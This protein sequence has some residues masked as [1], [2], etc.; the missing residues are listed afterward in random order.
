MRLSLIT[1]SHT[2]PGLWIMFHG[3]SHP[4]IPPERLT[5]FYLQL[6]YFISGSAIFLNSEIELNHTL[7]PPHSP[8]NDDPWLLTHSHTLRKTHSNLFEALWFYLQLCDFLKAEQM[9]FLFW[10]AQKKCWDPDFLPQLSPKCIKHIPPTPQGIW[11][12]LWNHK[13]WCCRDLTKNAI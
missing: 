8:P 2:F 9:F 7:T 11:H 4:H 6:Y 12:T 3:Y 10:E 13:K 1:H 5:V